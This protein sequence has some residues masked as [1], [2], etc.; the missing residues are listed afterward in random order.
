M[1]LEILGTELSYAHL[2]KDGVDWV[3][4]DHPSFQREGGLYGDSHGVYGDN[5]VRPLPGTDVWGSRRLEAL[6][7]CATGSAVVSGADAVSDRVCFC[8]PVQATLSCNE[9]GVQ[10]SLLPSCSELLVQARVVVWWVM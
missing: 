3:F 6:Q 8:T 4:V 9:P 7:A 1:V 5:Q 2:H 10:E